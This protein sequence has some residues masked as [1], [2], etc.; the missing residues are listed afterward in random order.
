MFKSLLPCGIFA[1]VN[2]LRGNGCLLHVYGV[3]CYIKIASKHNFT[4]KKDIFLV[5]ERRRNVTNRKWIRKTRHLWH[6]IKNKDI[7]VK[8]IRSKVIRVSMET[9]SFLDVFK[10]LTLLAVT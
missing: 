4:H 9:Q 3:S 8:R 5:W 1:E 6:C 10:I 7:F 2:I